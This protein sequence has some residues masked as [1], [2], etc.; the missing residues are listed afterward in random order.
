MTL[1]SNSA[2]APMIANLDL[3]IGVEVSGDPGEK[4][5]GYRALGTQRVR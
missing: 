4:G 1:R 2:I 5:N 3:P